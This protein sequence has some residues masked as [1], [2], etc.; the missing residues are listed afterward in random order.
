MY[1]SKLIDLYV[2]IQEKLVIKGLCSVVINSELKESS[3][4]L[5]V[6]AR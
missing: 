3:R 4:S 5:A 6:L 2:Y 1:E